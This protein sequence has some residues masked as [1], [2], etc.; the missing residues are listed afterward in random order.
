MSTSNE[1]RRRIA[2]EKLMTDLSKVFIKHQ[3][4]GLTLLQMCGYAMAMLANVIAKKYGA[5]AARQ[6]LLSLAEHAEQIEQ[7]SDDQALASF[8]AQAEPQGRA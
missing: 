1:K 7:I 4:G 5:E 8:L 2:A 6:T 3:R